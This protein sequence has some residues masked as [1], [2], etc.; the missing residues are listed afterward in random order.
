MKNTFGA[1][2]DDHLSYL[3]AFLMD[4]SLGHT[5]GWAGIPVPESWE[6]FFDPRSQKLGMAFFIP[7]AVPKI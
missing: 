2:A 1:A 6:W 4:A 7:F 5:Q 3:L